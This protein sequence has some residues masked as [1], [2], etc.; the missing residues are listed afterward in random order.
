[1]RRLLMLGILGFEVAS[2]GGR[3]LPF[4]IGSETQSVLD[5]WQQAGLV[6]GAPSAGEPGP[7]IDWSC[8]GRIDDIDLS[9][10]LIADRQGPQ[11]IV[12][13]ASGTTDRAHV[14]RAFT[15]LVQVTSL[16]AAARAPIA[17][18]LDSNGASDGSMPIS[19]PALVKRVAVATDAQG[20]VDLYVIPAGSSIPVG[21]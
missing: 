7:A 8:G 2:C 3:A 11:S 14:T 21:Q 19:S 10:R 12:V 9:L 17:A 18:W 1:M 4:P 16:L 6:C 20:H 13:G 15:N 5:D